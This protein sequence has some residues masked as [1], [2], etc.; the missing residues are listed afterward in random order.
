MLDESKSFLEL[1]GEDLRNSG[2]TLL[3]QVGKETYSVKL[4][5]ID[6]PDENKSDFYYL[7]KIHIIR[8]SGLR[9]CG[10][11]SNP[12][13]NFSI[14]RYTAWTLKPVGTVK[15][16]DHIKQGDDYLY[17]KET[18]LFPVE[19]NEEKLTL[20]VLDEDR[21]VGNLEDSVS[22]AKWK[23]N[24]RFE[25]KLRLDNDDGEIQVAV[26]MKKVRGSFTKHYTRR[27]TPMTTYFA[28][29]F[30]E[31]KTDWRSK[32]TKRWDD[33]CAGKHGSLKTLPS[34]NETMGEVS[35]S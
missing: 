34:L 17:L 21:V 28:S 26:T 7:M 10:D 4:D 29:F 27:Q 25:G 18:F 8:A 5:F 20:N 30:K 13:I 9:N 22:L 31:M 24:M 1:F 3:V 11:F 23:K 2:P 6:D 35:F 33:I 19:K 16:G 14:D 15:K 12:I 32:L